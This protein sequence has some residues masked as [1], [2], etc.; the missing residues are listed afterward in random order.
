[1]FEAA[2]SLNMLH[3][4]FANFTD[5]KSVHTDTGLVMSDSHHPPLSTDVLLSHVKNNVD[6]DNNNN[7][8]N[9]NCVF[10]YRIF[11]AG[12][13]TLLYNFLSTYHCSSVY[14]MLLY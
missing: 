1:V 7:N 8:N 12:N 11:A 14:K 10:S 5:L 3:I 2:E 9:N 13:I 6:D 4:V